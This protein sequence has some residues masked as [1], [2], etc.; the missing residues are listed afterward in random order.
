[1][2]IFDIFRIKPLLK[3]IRSILTFLKL[4]LKGD[5]SK[6]IEFQNYPQI[7]NKGRIFIGNGAYI[8]KNVS[9]KVASG[10]ILE[11]ED[12][13]IISNNCNFNVRK[14]SRIKIGRYSRINSGSIISGDINIEQN[15]IVAPN[16]VMIS[17]S[18]RLNHD[19]LSID[20]A[21]KAFGMKEGTITI[22]EHAFIGV[23]SVLLHSI[24]IG[25]GSIVGAQT[26]I[27]NSVGNNEVIVG[28][29]AVNISAKD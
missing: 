5:V 14:N 22:K 28:A 9:F 25:S 4:I 21:D 13:V 19:G 29:S 26:T 7:I 27:T 12:E 15:V 10:G 17:D 11:I 3:Y 24:E 1:M 6:K 8:G 20:E 18:H 16:V 2:I 23:G